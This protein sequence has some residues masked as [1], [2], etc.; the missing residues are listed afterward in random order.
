MADR[1]DQIIQKLRSGI[2]QLLKANGVTAFQGTASF[3]SRN[4]ILVESSAPGAE[5]VTL[6]AGKTIIC[7]GAASAMPGFLPKHERVV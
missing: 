1:K 2:K 4:R 3:E 6:T 7:T 5:K